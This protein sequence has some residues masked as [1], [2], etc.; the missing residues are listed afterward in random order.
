MF[1]GEMAGK[2]GKAGKVGKRG[3]DAVAVCHPQK[4][5]E[6]RDRQT[7]KAS[8]RSEATRTGRHDDGAKYGGVWGTNSL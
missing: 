1:S 7:R 3:S 5:M 2:W 4:Q 6:S 8:K